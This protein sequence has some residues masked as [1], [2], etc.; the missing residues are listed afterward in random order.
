MSVNR[1]KHS[2]SQ[3]P[4]DPGKINCVQFAYPRFDVRNNLMSNTLLTFAVLQI[5]PKRS[6]Q[7]IPESLD[8]DGDNRVLN[9]FLVSLPPLKDPTSN[10]RRK[11]LGN[12]VTTPPAKLGPI[13]LQLSFDFVFFSSSPS[14]PGGEM[15]DGVDDATWRSLF[16]HDHQSGGP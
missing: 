15:L 3:M 4:W 9:F 2:L 8:P 7:H 1:R 5:C 14:R 16:C 10:R 11:T 6:S 12:L 13:S